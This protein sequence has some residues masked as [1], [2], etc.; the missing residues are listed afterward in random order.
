MV[1]LI[2]QSIVGRGWDFPPYLND[3]NRIAMVEHE[4]NIRRSIFVI[5]NT[6]PGERVMRPDFGCEIHEM[7]FAPAN[8]QTAAVIERMTL[9][10]LHRWEPRINLRQVRAAPGYD[11]YGQILIDIVY[12]IKGSHDV[13]SLVYPFYLL[14]G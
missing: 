8:D 11:D 10:A 13:H 2:S 14:P 1:N 4:A 5:L 6:A 7:I 9:E 3:R 12:E